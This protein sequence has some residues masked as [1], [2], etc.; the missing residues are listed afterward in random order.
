MKKQRNNN[1]P[2]I[3]TRYILWLALF[4]GFFA[5]KDR[6]TTACYPLD[7]DTGDWGRLP[8][9]YISFRIYRS[10]D[11]SLYVGL[12]GR[13]LAEE[14]KVYDEQHKEPHLYSTNLDGIIGFQVFDDNHRPIWDTRS[15][16]TFYIEYPNNDIDTLFFE[17]NGNI[18]QPCPDY[19]AKVA[20]IDYLSLSYN[21]KLYI[22]KAKQMSRAILYK[23]Y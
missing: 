1:S 18:I 2:P 21:R 14:L 11:S 4:L 19:D 13:Y 16:R 6:N 23:K 17:Y 22:N 20:K 15:S 9:T 12:D 5:C 10:R 7:F 3:W 8:E